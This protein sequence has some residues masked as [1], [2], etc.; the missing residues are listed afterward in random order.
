M[1]LFRVFIS[2][3]R[4]YFNPTDPQVVEFVVIGDGQ[5]PFNSL[6]RYR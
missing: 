6:W 1:E 2:T 4:W 5:L 3:G